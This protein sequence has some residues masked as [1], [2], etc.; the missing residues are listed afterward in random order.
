LLA[1]SEKV[2][3]E[4]CQRIDKVASFTSKWLKIAYPVEYLVQRKVFRRLTPRWMTTTWLL[5]ERFDWGQQNTT[6]SE[7]LKSFKKK[8]LKRKRKDSIQQES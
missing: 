7:I 1:T 4:T 3:H 6:P 8:S 5:R 2:G